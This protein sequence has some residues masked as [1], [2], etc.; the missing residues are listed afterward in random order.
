MTDH[1]RMPARGAQSSEATLLQTLTRGLDVLEL[2]ATSNGQATAKMIAST[3]GLRSSTCYHLLRTLKQAGYVVRVEGGTYDV[4]PRAGALGHH[5]DTRFGPSPEISAL[6]SRL[7]NKTRETAYVCGW[8]HGSIVMQ[9]FIGGTHPL[10]V[11]QLEVGY[12]GN[13]HARASCKSVLAHLPEDIVAAMFSGVELAALTPKTTTSYPALVAQLAEVRGRGYAIDDEEFHEGV[14]CVSSAF[15][16]AQ[17]NPVGSFTVSVP[18]NRSE[19]LFTSVAA[20]VH[21]AA[22][23][24]TTMLRSGRLVVN[25]QATPA[26]RERG[27]RPRQTPS[28]RLVDPS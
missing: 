13:M 22:S 7:H 23:L 9:Q 27:W 19:S 5:L 24:A 14:C 26:S 11:K 15:F 28:M 10:V 21:E 12:S 8:Y 1:D 4:G 3:I 17:N 2:V 20:E 18:S 25:E 16:D 6:L